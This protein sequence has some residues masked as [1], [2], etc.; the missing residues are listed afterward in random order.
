MHTI[1]TLWEKNY[2]EVIM[3][4]N[5]KRQEPTEQNKPSPQRRQPQLQKQQPP[6]QQKPK[7]RAK[8]N[9]GALTIAILIIVAII[10]LI[11]P[12]IIRTLSGNIS[13]TI[14]LRDG[15]LEDSFNATA[16]VIREE[17]ILRSDIEGTSIATY[18]EGDRVP[19][20]AVV[21][22]VID[23]SSAELVDRIRSLN[24]RISQARDEIMNNAGFVDQ[25]IININNEIDEN[26]LKLPGMNVSGNLF[27]YS[28]IYR[29]IE[30]QLDR[31][32]D[33]KSENLNGTSYLNE[34]ISERNQLERTIEGR[35]SNIINDTPGVISYVVDGLEE[36]V[37]P[38]RLTNMSV[39]GFETMLQEAKKGNA[40]NT[41]RA[42]AKI[43]TGINYYMA[44]SVDADNVRNLNRGDMV[45]VRVNGKNIIIRMQVENI[46][47]DGGKALIVFRANTALAEMTAIRI[48]NIDI[49]M[50]RVT[51]IR[52]PQ[53]A[54][55]NINHVTNRGDIAVIKSG[56]VHYVEAEILFMRGGYAIIQNYSEDARV[57]FELNDH[58]IIEPE[59]V[60]HGQAF[61]H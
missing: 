27:G 34:L 53:R 57:K 42:Y 44:A 36:E 30:V 46:V 25:E 23:S 21:A 56:H 37:V 32:S 59:R 39:A 41:N 60:N 51:G 13:S 52:V 19:N 20:G 15:M 3:D 43:I 24:V 8:I 31:R 28:E 54:L 22:T 58:V 50:N 5:N 29:N 11:G 40:E 49:I 45:D 47:R 61:N 9:S 10:F 55:M 38:S 35:M 26:I 4:K 48:A 14:V 6:T 1:F 7:K 16:V 2:E 33:F 12:M 18:R 17:R